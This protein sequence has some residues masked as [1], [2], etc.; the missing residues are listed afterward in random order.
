[1]ATYRTLPSGKTQAQLRLSGRKLMSA[2]FATLAEAMRWVDN[3]TA[4]AGRVNRERTVYDDPTTDHSQT[5]KE[6]GREF[7][8]IGL[9]G[10]KTQH[11]TIGQLAKV[12]RKSSLTENSPS[13]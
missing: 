3:K 10:K 1:M 12:I 2:S 5:L 7:C 6:L 8:L 13:L 4:K 11:E 9:K